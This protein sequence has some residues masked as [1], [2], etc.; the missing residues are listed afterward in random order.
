MNALAPNTEMTN[1]QMMIKFF[2]VDENLYSNT[3]AT[4]AAIASR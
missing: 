4:P 2:G 1:V 3:N